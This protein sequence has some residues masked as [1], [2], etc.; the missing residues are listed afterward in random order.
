MEIKYVNALA[1]SGKTHWVIEKSIAL[2]EDGNRVIIAVP[3]KKLADEEYKPGLKMCL[4]PVRVI[5]TDNSEESA[6]SDI[7]AHLLDFQ[8][9]GQILVITQTALERIAPFDKSKW[10]LFVDEIP[11]VFQIYE[12]NLSAS[13]T[14]LTTHLTLGGAYGPYQE[15]VVVNA[16]ALD[17]LAKSAND[18]D[19]QA[20]FKDT[21]RLLV[22]PH[23]KSYVKPS[24]Y[25]GLINKAKG[26][27]KLSINS[28]LQPSIYEGFDEIYVCGAHF[29]DSLLYK[30]WNRMGVSFNKIRNPNLRFSN[31]DGR[32]VTIYYITE[33]FWSKNLAFQDKKNPLVKRIAQYFECHLG[34][35]DFIY[36]QNKGNPL[37]ENVRYNR[38]IPCSP[39][40]LNNYSNIDTV[41]ALQAR[42]PPPAQIKFIEKTQG[43]DFSSIS[44]AIHKEI[45][46]QNV[47]RCSLRDPNN[48]NPKSIYVP[49]SKTAMWL[50]NEL[51]GS[52]L[53]RL[54]AGIAELEEAK[55]DPEKAP[56]S[57]AERQAKA[58]D[59]RRRRDALKLLQTPMSP[60][61]H[62]K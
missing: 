45:V 37:F 6:V 29:T 23:W 50:Q 10:I 42:N 41:V 34:D 2:A 26:H 31:H 20:R 27:K 25:Q 35:K 55:K 61:T 3:T 8:P 4:L 9:D 5:H 58:R 56:K 17:V 12:S 62:V 7:N 46:Y 57:D 19:I 54:E 47:M 52:K 15:L 22:S 44:E 21:A 60:S 33:T 43:M 59:K 13:H 39:H 1:G 24:Q 28:V 53:V 14:Y 38:M 51:P 18:D 16:P 30:T 32:G 40:G 49:D 48:T 36:S 11:Q